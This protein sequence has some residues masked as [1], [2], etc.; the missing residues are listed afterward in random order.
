[1]E[2]SNDGDSN[3]LID[4]IM[5]SPE[6]SRLQPIYWQSSGLIRMIDTTVDAYEKQGILQFL[7][8]YFPTQ[9]DYIFVQFAI[10]SLKDLYKNVDIKFSVHDAF[11]E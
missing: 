11:V 5:D 10:L 2:D 6:K 3:Q 9:T 4:Q 8:C 1:M 7:C